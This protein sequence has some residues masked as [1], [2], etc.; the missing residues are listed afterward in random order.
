MDISRR[1]ANVRDLNKTKI[2]LRNGI[3]YTIGKEDVKISISGVELGRDMSSVFG[4]SDGIRTITFPA[5]VR[6][7][8]QGSF[9]N[10]K[11][12]KSVV[13]NDGLEILGTDEY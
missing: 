9:Y 11:C 10:V 3:T 1:A 5:M 12:L 8:R 2:V 7:I 6:T 4:G 13:L